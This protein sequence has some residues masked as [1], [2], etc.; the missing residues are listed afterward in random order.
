MS[1]K[2]NS[3]QNKQPSRYGKLLT[4]Y[5]N[6][7]DVMLTFKNEKNKQTTASKTE[8]TFSVTWQKIGSIFW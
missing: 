3:L 2:E 1:F 4:G 8:N 5:S 7:P 6:S